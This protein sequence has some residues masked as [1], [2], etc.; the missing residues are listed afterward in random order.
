MEIDLHI[1]N[2][3]N[4][5]CKHCVYTSGEWEMPDMTFETIEKLVLSFK[6]MGVEEVHITGG[7]PLLNKDF[8]KIAKYLNENGFGTRVQTNGMLITKEIATKLKECGIE[9]VLISIDG[10]E[11]S[12]NSFRNNENSFKKAIEAVKICIDAGIYTRV[13]TVIN[14]S[15]IQDL[16]QLI[17]EINK[18]KPNQHSFFYLT[19]IGRGKNIKELVLSLEEW[20]EIEEMVRKAGIDNNC[21]DNIKLQNVIK[22][23]NENLTCRND[24]CLILANGDVYHCVFYIYSPYKLGNIY[25]E[26]LDKLWSKNIDRI[27]D[28]TTNNKSLNKEC[29]KASGGCKC[30][31]SGLAYA[32]T[33]S[34]DACDPRCKPGKELIPSC[35]R[36]YIDMNR[37]I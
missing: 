11:Q 22:N 20:K 3:C 36:T 24:N 25:E 13:N 5:K 34:V 4:L 14:K 17:K 15:N 12:H 26:D 10:L 21:I 35:I 19:P 32:F 8:F 30:K 18:L 28:I 29:N 7:E 6:N 9:Y 33:G 1:T 27:L 37:R 16:P 23:K 31:C 2:H